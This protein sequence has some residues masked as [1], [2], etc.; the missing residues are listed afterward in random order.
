MVGPCAQRD[1]FFSGATRLKIAKRFIKGLGRWSRIPP[2][3]RAGPP[4]PR[5]PS[6]RSLAG[7][8]AR[9]NGQ[10]E[11]ALEY[12]R[13]ALDIAVEAFGEIH[14]SVASIYNSMAVIYDQKLDFARAAG[15]RAPDLSG[16]PMAWAPGARDPLGGQT[17]VTVAPLIKGGLSVSGASSSPAAEL[18]E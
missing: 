9:S 13:K 4:P 12:Y 7:G 16:A 3:G 10:H 8:L 11:Q 17:R 18:R 2:W 6:P 15:A 5:F 1:N 14:S